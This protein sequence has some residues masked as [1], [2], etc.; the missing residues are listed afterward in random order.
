VAPGSPTPAPGIPF[1]LGLGELVALV[2]VV[3]LVVAAL[4]LARDRLPFEED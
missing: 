4:L 2:A 1:G 3:A